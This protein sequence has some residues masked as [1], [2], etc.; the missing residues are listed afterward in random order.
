[1]SSLI[2]FK[3]VLPKIWFPP[4]L[5]YFGSFCRFKPEGGITTV[6]ARFFKRSFGSKI[7]EAAENEEKLSK[8]GI[9]RIV[10]MANYI[11]IVCARSLH[12]QFYSW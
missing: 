10:F 8:D 12:Y 6:L 1:M 3:Y 2:V 4:D 11:G 5:N 7:E 9:L